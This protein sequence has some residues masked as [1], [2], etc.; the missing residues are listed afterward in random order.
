MEQGDNEEIARSVESIGML[1]KLGRAGYIGVQR[2][3]GVGTDMQALEGSVLVAASTE[4]VPAEHICMRRSSTKETRTKLRRGL[5]RHRL[6]E[7]M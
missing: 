5:Q 1:G 7:W 3:Y 4:E 2:T 6:C